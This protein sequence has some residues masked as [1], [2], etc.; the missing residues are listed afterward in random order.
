VRIAVTGASGFVGGRVAEALARAGHDVLPFGRRPASALSHAIHGYVAWDFAAGPLAARAA[1]AVVHCGARVG[2]WGPAST[3]RTVNVC[4]TTAVLRSFPDVERFVHIST[5]SV[6]ASNRARARLR[7]DAP[8]EADALSAYA[9]SKVDAERVVTAG[10][11][12]AIILRPHIV[13][14][15]GDPTLM[16]RVL[17]ARRLGR[18][19]VAGDGSNHVSVTH[20]D[21]LVI[22]VERALS[23]PVEGPFN[24]ADAEAVTMDA[25]L[26]TMLRRH[27][28][29]DCLTYIPR[30]LAW[31]LA[32]A[33][34]CGWRAARATHAPP[35]T[36]FMVT[37]LA[38][39]FT[40]DLALARERLGYVPRWSYRDEPARARPWTPG[41]G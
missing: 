24:I 6:Y 19:P 27:G 29:R 10:T 28:V 8:L 30:T 9:L 13:Y 5:A 23:A 39:E 36:R 38:D 22:A 14:G 20:V 34:E 2:D 35:L 1:D 37:N 7:E 21:N 33:L 31:P 40:L 15:P 3:Y 17:A 26:R 4:G 18:L 41:R 16:P 25:L 12:R 11:R 32:I